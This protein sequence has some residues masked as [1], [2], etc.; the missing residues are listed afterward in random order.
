MIYIYNIYIYIDNIQ[1]VSGCKDIQESDSLALPH[2][3]RY[4]S[5]LLQEQSPGLSCVVAGKMWRHIRLW[6]SCARRSFVSKCQTMIYIYNNLPAI[7]FTAPGDV[8]IGWTSPGS[9]ALHMWRDFEVMCKVCVL[10]WSSC[11]FL[12]QVH[13]FSSTQL[14]LLG[15]FDEDVTRVTNSV[16]IGCKNSLRWSIVVGNRRIKGGQ[17]EGSQPWTECWIFRCDN[18]LD[19]HVSVQP[20]Y[21][22]ICP[23]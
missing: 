4:A 5:C 3:R 19:F 17:R 16:C 21:F 20:G 11:R 22:W 2:S 12:S 6:S 8:E 7:C 1:I 14:T 23:L 13:K 9:K 15:S 10:S 18:S